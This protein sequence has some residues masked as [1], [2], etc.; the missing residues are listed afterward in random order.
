MDECLADVRLLLIS[1]AAG[2]K[3]ISEMEGMIEA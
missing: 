2:K 3:Q 1:F